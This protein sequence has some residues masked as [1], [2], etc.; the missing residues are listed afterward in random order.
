MEKGCPIRRDFDEWET[1]LPQPNAGFEESEPS[2]ARICGT[3]LA[4]TAQEPALSEVEGMG[5][6]RV[7]SC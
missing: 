4:K 5:Q 1:M 7:Y 3:T 2:T 6:P